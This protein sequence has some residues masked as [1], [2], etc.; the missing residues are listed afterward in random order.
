MGGNTINKEIYDYFR[1]PDNIMTCS[2]FIQQRN[3]L[4]PEALKYLFD[5]FNLKCEDKATYEGYHLYAVD[6]SDINIAYNENSETHCNW[7]KE[8]IGIKGFNQFHL[9]AMYNVLNKVYVDCLIQ[10]R[11]K[12]NERAAAIDM[13]K[14]INTEKPAII[15]ADRGYESLNLF[16]TINR[17]NNLEYLIRIKNSGWLKEID[18]LPLKQLD[19]E[20]SFQLRTT[21]TKKDKKLFA[22]GKAKWIAGPSKSG[23]E[24]KDVQWMFESPFN[25]TLRVVR[26]EIGDGN[27]ETIITSLN[28]FQFPL[29][30]IKELYHLRWG[31]E[32]SFRELKYVVGLTNFHCKKEEFIIQE[33]YARLIM[34]NFSMC[35]AK[36]VV[37]NKSDSCRYK[38]QVNYT[39]AIH[40]CKDFYRDK[41]DC[42][43]VLEDLI[44]QYIEPIREGRSDM[45]KLKP[46]TFIYFLYRVA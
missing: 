38:Y 26:F 17:I 21:Q 45:R 20:I 22:E 44:L 11:P 46:K 8:S 16:E 1:T 37:I 25:M 32:T 9:N 13:A 41:M 30:K 12:A 33:I 3:K 43:V 10:A 15:I 40:L 5:S 27:W 36:Q 14:R 2:A 7:M 35:I 31:I 23:K 19:K 28:R 4:K 29:E 34:Y 24:K 39:M 42:D 18:N 6:G